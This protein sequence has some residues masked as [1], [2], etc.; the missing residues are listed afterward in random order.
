[1]SRALVISLGAVIGLSLGF[2]A[3]SLVK[4]IDFESR[5]FTTGIIV[6]AFVIGAVVSDLIFL[7]FSEIELRLCF[8]ILCSGLLVQSLIDF[9]THRLVRQISH[10]MAAS[11][12]LLLGLHAVNSS[13]FEVLVSASVCAVFGVAVSFFSNKVSSGS[14]G[15]G[16]VR[17][18]AVL[19]WHLGFLSYS[20]AIWALFSACLLA[21]LFGVVMIVSRRG[22]WHQ[23]IAF[24]PFLSLGSFVAI[25]ADEVSS[26]VFTA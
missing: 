10:A 26:Y 25:F 13:N 5:E 7:R 20:T 17:L 15:A 4:R 21:G 12:A 6:V 8:A 23:R 24:G 22:S 1:L 3:K 14:L 16:D 19:G 18:M 11:G 9:F 2:A